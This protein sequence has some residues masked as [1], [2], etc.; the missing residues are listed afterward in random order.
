MVRQCIQ[1]YGSPQ[2]GQLAVVVLVAGD[3]DAIVED[4]SLEQWS[5]EQWSLEQWSLEQSFLVHG[6]LRACTRPS[7]KDSCAG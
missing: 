2:T 5:L 3:D 6:M 7:G 4:R 1:R